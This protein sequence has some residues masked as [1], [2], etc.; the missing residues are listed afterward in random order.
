MNYIQKKTRQFID[1]IGDGLEALAAV[2]IKGIKAIYRFT[3]DAW[4]IA[5]PL[6]IELFLCAYFFNLFRL[7]QGSDIALLRYFG[8]AAFFFML[9]VHMAVGYYIVM[10]LPISSKITNTAYFFISLFTF[11]RDIIFLFA[12][13]LMGS[14]IVLY[15]VELIR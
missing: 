8:G 9:V 1:L 13:M 14:V 15:L 10:K 3:K 12:G 11:L 4:Q 7:G 6:Y 5:I 2:I